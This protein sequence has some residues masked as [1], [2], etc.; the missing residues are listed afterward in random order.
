MSC[1]DQN[2]GKALCLWITVSVLAVVMPGTAPADG[3]A[4]TQRQSSPSVFVQQGDI[5]LSVTGKKPARITR[6]GNC[7]EAVMSPNHKLIAFVRCTTVPDSDP[8]GHSFQRE[9]NEIWLMQVDGSNAVCAVKGRSVA[10]DGS[11][12]CGLRKV[13]FGPDGRFLY[14]VSDDSVTSPAVYVLDTKT[15]RYRF[16]SPGDVVGVVK[17]GE[18]RGGVV[19]WQHRYFLAGGSYN[20]YWLLDRNGKTIGPVGPERKS[21]VSFLCGSK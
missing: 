6:Y 9:L 15:G 8:E 4:T 12:F 18:Y 7:R 3:V 16:F 19:L 2:V 13:H 20:W 17:S 11:M 21:A 10:P 5:Y 14:F 1:I